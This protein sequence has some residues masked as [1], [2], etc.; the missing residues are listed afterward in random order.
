MKRVRIVP[1][2]FVA[3][4][5]TL[6][7]SAQ[8]YVFEIDPH[9]SRLGFTLDATLHTVHGAFQLKDGSVRFDPSTG[10]AS[11]LITVDAISADTGNRGRDHKMHKDILESAR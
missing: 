9:Q 2:L 1:A 5:F 7:A 3:F 8:T 6:A 11:G 4:V 10:A